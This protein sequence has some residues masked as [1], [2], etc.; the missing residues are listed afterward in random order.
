MKKGKFLIFSQGRTGS[1]LLMDLLSSHPEIHC[2]G[3]LLYYRVPFPAQFVKLKSALTLKKHFGFKVKI[4]QL[5]EIQNIKDPREFIMEFYNRGWKIISLKRENLLRHV[6]SF[7][8]AEENKKYH[9][10]K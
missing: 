6:I 1:T 3:E 9:F 2:D 5:V 10:K 8:F 7:W 4:Y